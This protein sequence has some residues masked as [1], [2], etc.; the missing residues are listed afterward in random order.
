MSKALWYICAN[1]NRSIKHYVCML[2]TS[3]LITLVEVKRH[4]LL[5]LLLGSTTM[6]SPLSGLIHCL[7]SVSLSPQVAYASSH[8]G[9]L[10][11]VSEALP[12]FESSCLLQQP[13]SALCLK[14]QL[15]NTSVTSGVVPCFPTIC[16]NDSLVFSLGQTSAVKILGAC[17]YRFILIT[18][19]FGL[20][21]WAFYL[22]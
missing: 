21:N 8:L 22:C 15:G 2:L 19:Y 1:A 5:L 12:L 7:P 13:T 11:F 9:P 18:S 10:W 3:F 16:R 4:V 14:R 6:D 17:L 20:T